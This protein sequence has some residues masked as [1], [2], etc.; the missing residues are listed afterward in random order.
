MH[1]FHALSFVFVP[2]QVPSSSIQIKNEI[3]T[4]NFHSPSFIHSNS[5]R[6]YD[7]F[8]HIHDWVIKRTVNSTANGC[9][10][11]RAN[12]IKCESIILFLFNWNGYGIV[13]YYFHFIQRRTQYG[14]HDNI[15]WIIEQKT[16]KEC[17]ATSL[18]IEFEFIVDERTT[19]S[20]QIC[21]TQ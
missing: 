17:T 5:C 6:Y 1:V 4:Q 13:H 10:V 18:E 16:S 8:I 3:A 12:T 7:D 15:K 14:L 20:T 9:S 19:C 11:F 2:L 21:R